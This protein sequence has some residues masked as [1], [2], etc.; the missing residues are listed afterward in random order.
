VD[1]ELSKLLNPVKME[2]AR[3]TADANVR[4]LN[5][6]KDECKCHP[7]CNTCC[8]RLVYI[9]VAEA[10]L[11]YNSL[12]KSG[13]WK[14][15]AARAKELFVLSRN[16]N[17]I[18]WIKM[19]IP[20]PVLN[21]ETGRCLS[22]QTRPISCSTYL[23]RSN[24]KGC[25]P[26]NFEKHEYVH[27]PMDDLVERFYLSMKKHVANHGVL[28]LVLPLPVALLFAER[29]NSVKNVDANSFVS[30]MKNEAK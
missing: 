10:I 15:V 12:S 11:V 18:S 5:V 2:L 26:W 21:P 30:M 6:L 7:G 4:R 8:S 1:I 27:Y 19:N 20:C 9:T 14:E 29:V 16:S 23:V 28:S 17:P 22:Y 13:K 25:D 24:P 3:S